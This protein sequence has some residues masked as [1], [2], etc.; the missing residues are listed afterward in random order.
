M[1]FPE[2]SVGSRGTGKFN[3]AIFVERGHATG[4]RLAA[5]PIRFFGQT[6]G[7]I[8]RSKRE[9]GAYVAHAGSGNKNVA[10]DFGDLIGDREVNQRLR[11][12]S[13]QRNL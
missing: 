12:V 4:R 7:V 6:D 1:P 9:R 3:E 10:G 13:R 2:R 11:S 8:S 5:D